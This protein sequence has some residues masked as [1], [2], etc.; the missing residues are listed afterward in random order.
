[1]KKILIC[2]IVGSVIILTSGI[3]LAGSNY[4]SSGNT[5]RAAVKDNGSMRL[6]SSGETV[7]TGEKEVFWNIQGPKGDQGATGPQGLQGPKGDTG[8]IGPIG[9]QGP[10]GDT[11]AVGPQGIQGPRGDQGDS[12]PVG[13]QGA[14]GA[15]VKVKSG[16]VTYDG[17]V[18]SAGSG[19]RI[20]HTSVGKYYVNFPTGTWSKAPLVTI[21]PAGPVIDVVPHI[22]SITWNPNDLSGYFEVTVKKLSEDHELVDASFTYIAVE[23]E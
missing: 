7:K 2:T 21:S 6:L 17:R 13:P 19:I 3:A 4:I 9:S 16:F 20:Q 15:G 23:S 12:G 8:A 11:G 22:D 5:L 10:K 14:P 18:G 1:M